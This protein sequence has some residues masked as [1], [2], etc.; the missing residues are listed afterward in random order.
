MG[1]PLFVG[2]NELQKVSH[3]RKHAFTD[4]VFGPYVSTSETSR[5]QTLIALEVLEAYL[6]NFSA[7]RRITSI[8]SR[9]SVDEA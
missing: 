5:V 2:V 9:A 6:G 3:R 8:P 4:V 1:I 7:S